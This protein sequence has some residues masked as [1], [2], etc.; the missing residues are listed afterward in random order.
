MSN[1]EDF[2][3][4]VGYVEGQLKMYM[5]IHHKKSLSW[6]EIEHVFRDIEVE[7]R[8]LSLPVVSD[9]QL[10]LFDEN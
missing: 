6:Y 7:L 5:T 2:L 4:I 3:S 8:Q 10:S 1:I 9:R